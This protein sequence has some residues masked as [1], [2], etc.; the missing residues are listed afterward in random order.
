MCKVNL[1]V[2]RSLEVGGPEL[3]CRA[4]SILLKT[5]FLLSIFSSYLPF[6]CRVT[7]INVTWARLRRN[8]PVLVVLL[9]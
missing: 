6:S 8:A 3:I 5:V 2:F 9:Q 1:V 4:L 7:I